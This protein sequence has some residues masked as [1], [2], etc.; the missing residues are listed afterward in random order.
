MSSIL[1]FY[2]GIFH[3]THSKNEKEDTKK[4]TWKS[5]EKE[6]DYAYLAGCDYDCKV[7]ADKIAM[8]R[9]VLYGYGD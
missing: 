7:V 2:S 3:E 6:F 5:L 1:D 4:K 8:D 9:V